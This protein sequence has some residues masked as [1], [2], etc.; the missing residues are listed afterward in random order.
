MKEVVGNSCKP[1]LPGSK[2]M[3]L[4]TFERGDVLEPMKRYGLQSTEVC[5]KDGLKCKCEARHQ[6]SI[7]LEKVMSRPFRMETVAV[8]DTGGG[9]D[10]KRR[11]GG[12]SSSS[13]SSSSSSS[14]SSSAAAADDEEESHK[15]E[16]VVP[17]GILQEAQ[18]KLAAD[19]RKYGSVSFV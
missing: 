18:A 15:F 7:P 10:I 9:R 2:R 8:G 19:S 14:S 3:C 4:R 6:N 5:E 16:Y 17:P 13:A 12:A 11:R 1:K